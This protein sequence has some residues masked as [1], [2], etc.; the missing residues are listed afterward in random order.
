MRLSN[1]DFMSSTSSSEKPTQIV[2]LKDFKSLI[3]ECQ[4]SRKVAFEVGEKCFS[5]EIRALT[6]VEMSA[7][8]QIT[9]LIPPKTLQDRFNPVTNRTE[10]ILDHDYSDPVFV[11]K[12]EKAERIRRAYILEKGLVG[13]SPEGDTQD[14]KMAFFEENF[15]LNILE[16]LRSQ[17]ESISDGEIKVI[18]SAN[19]FFGNDSD[20]PQS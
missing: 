13:L 3:E 19:F 6:S 9:A 16:F 4:S 17:I 8:K 12:A 20:A 11:E 5:L 18:E 7:A 2:S 15:P 14:K 1:H 10:K